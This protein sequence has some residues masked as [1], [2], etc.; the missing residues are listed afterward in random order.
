MLA[1]PVIA[2]PRW[3]SAFF[4]FGLA[5]LSSTAG[6]DWL[7]TDDPTSGPV[8]AGNPDGSTPPPGDGGAD[9]TTPPGD[10]G[11]DGDAAPSLN[12]GGE[13]SAPV[14]CSVDFSVGQVTLA[15]GQKVYLV[16]NSPAIG[17]WSAASAFELTD[18]GGGTWGGAVVLGDGA[19]V[20]FKFIKKGTSVE[21]ESWGATSNRSMRVRCDADGGGGSYVGVFNQ[22]PPDAT[23]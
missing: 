16:G 6:C 7:A 8:S 15:A 1:R 21:W 14:T 17:S 22:K 20:E 5:V 11:A 9:V 12:D 10:A 13:A 19:S 23:P 4:L 3:G 2:A 18:R